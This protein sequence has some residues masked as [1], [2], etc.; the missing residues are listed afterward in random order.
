MSTHALI[1]EIRDRVIQAMKE[2]PS[3]MTD[4][5]KSVWQDFQ[6]H[7]TYGSSVVE[8]ALN[9]F[10]EGKILCELTDLPLPVRERLWW[11]TQP[12]SEAWL[13]A[14]WSYRNHEKCDETLLKVPDDESEQ[15][16]TQ[17]IL[18]ELTKAAEREP[19]D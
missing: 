15:H 1:Q 8:N 16:L 11:E 13:E 9:M 19:I 17:L 3:A 18:R 7:L 6:N 10:I 2:Q 5:R 4:D 14:E 12:G